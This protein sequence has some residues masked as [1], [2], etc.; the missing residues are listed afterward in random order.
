MKKLLFLLCACFICLTSIK[1][2]SLTEVL[3]LKNGSVIRGTIIEQVPNESI[4]IQ[5]LDGSIFAYSM[6]DVLKITK[7]Q[8]INNY[9]NNSVTGF[10]F[11]RTG[12]RNNFAAQRGYKGFVEFGGG[13]GVGDWAG[14]FV[15]LTTSHGYQFNPHIF[16][17]AGAGFNYDFGNELIFIPVF[18]DFRY[19]IL[20]RNITPVFGTKI[21]YS[22]Y[23]GQ[24]VFFNP[25]IGCRFGLSESFALNLTFNY[26]LQTEEAEYYWSG[27]YESETVLLHTIGFKLGIEF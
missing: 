27:Y 5:T 18:A 22:V 10:K 17:G 14:N 2:Q 20:N 6:A 12:F 13:F 9:S 1:A 4:K 21:G 11:Q 16:V 19:N 25:S 15:G 24:G 23:D 26:G 8:A 3:H 7:E